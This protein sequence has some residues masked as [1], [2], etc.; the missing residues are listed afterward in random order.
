MRVNLFLIGLFLSTNLFANAFIDS[1][2]YKEFIARKPIIEQT[3][4]DPKYNTVTD[5][6]G[7]L[8]VRPG[9]EI[10]ISDIIPWSSWWYPSRD[11]YIFDRPNALAP[12]EIYDQVHRR[13]YGVNPQ[14]ALYEKN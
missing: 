11:T 4:R 3:I 2:F 13:I 7:Q 10:Y 12:L 5:K 9:E 1:E 6:Y 14:S 8:V